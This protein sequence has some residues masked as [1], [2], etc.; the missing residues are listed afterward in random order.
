MPKL[1]I[2]NGPDKG[3]SFEI[4]NGGTSVVGRENA[5]E[6]ALRD[7]MVSRRHFE[8][9]CKRE[10]YYIRDLDSSNGTLL[11]GLL[12]REGRK[13]NAN[14]RI[15]AGDTLLTF[16][17]DQPHPLLGKEIAGY[18]ILD[19]IGRGGMGTV[20]R[21]MQTS[22]DR[23]VALKILAPHLVKDTS[24]IN[25]FIREARAAGA[26]SHPNIVQ[27]YD[28]GV[29]EDIY[30][31]SMEYI[32]GG[33]V[34][35]ILNSDK[36]IP[37]GRALR[38][39]RDA[40]QGLEYAE[41]KGIIHRD[42][43]PGNLMVGNGGVIKIGDLGIARSTGGE[44][45]VSQKDGVSGSPH[46]IAPEQ[47]QGKDIDHRVDLYSLGI[48]F[49]QM[50]CGKTPYSGTTPREV[51]LKHIK[52]EPQRLSERMPDLPNDI[53]ELVHS[54]I[55]KDREQRVPSATALL[56]QLEPFLA[57]Y[58]EDATEP[59]PVEEGGGWKRGLVFVIGAVLLA[60][61]GMS[62]AFFYNN[63]R[64]EREAEDQRRQDL[65]Q[66][67]TDGFEKLQSDQLAA[68]RQLVDALNAAEN[69][70]E[71]LVSRRDDL[72]K[73]VAEAEAQAARNAREDEAAAALRSL[74]AQLPAHEPTR[75]GVKRLRKFA[76]SNAKTKAAEEATSQAD[77][78]EAAL[79][80]RDRHVA[81]AA[82]HLDE[83]LQ[84]AEVYVKIGKYDRARTELLEF[85]EKYNDTPSKGE[86]DEAFAQ[87]ESSVRDRWR[88]VRNNAQQKQ[89]DK[90][91]IEAQDVIRRFLRDIGG[92]DDI[93]EEANALLA[94][95][96]ADDGD[97]A[98]TTS[99]EE[100]SNRALSKALQDG[101]A[102]LK[103]SFQP[104]RAINDHLS[105]FRLNA[106]LTADAKAKRDAHVAFLQRLPDVIDEF[107]DL[108][109]PAGAELEI[110]TQGKTK[111]VRLTRV[112][113][114]RVDYDVLPGGAGSFSNWQELDDT[115]RAKI[116]LTWA[117]TPTQ[118]LYCGFLAFINAD[119]T[120]GSDALREAAAADSDLESHRQALRELFD[121]V[122]KAAEETNQ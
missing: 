7:E 37:A 24:F 49:Y 13:L 20:Y 36:M 60:G 59:M 105:G 67:V 17:D 40:A 65:T 115:S 32:P 51:I 1:V 116:L 4:K 85:D 80:A 70:P 38:I 88:E 64:Q 25:L 31:F 8:I 39:V 23:T 63:W 81:D 99:P 77:T 82:E 93:V 120:G 79:D 68:A 102:T 29:H 19:R 119:V 86:L 108:P 55:A 76:G 41:S 114:D 98:P 111:R 18:K 122:M 42:I 33:S 87:L 96:G 113:R 89:A 90:R 15:E 47:A 101:W 43:K 110:V 44:E 26:L 53:V 22:L 100:I 66:Q 107:K 69:F 3:R 58:P 71:E 109:A 21:A 10:A 45:S 5:A 72:A 117:R 61:I 92:F 106:K 112:T 16:V 30:F 121:V 2:E 56:Q 62:S 50:L 35:D 46:Y 103:D 14:D 27:V 12:L 78:M 91:P 52:E 118:K 94:K 48:S 104:R 28:V 74:L 75:D 97:A 34:E 54:L 9:E 95:I 83:R 57:R 73:A 11:N 6:F 84:E